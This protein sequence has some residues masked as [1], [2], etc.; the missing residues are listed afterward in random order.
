[1]QVVLAAVPFVLIA[2]V[3]ALVLRRQL[4]GRTVRPRPA[5]KPR[6]TTLTLHVSPDRMDDDLRDLLRKS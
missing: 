1:M 6:A 2:L 4:S 5:R 3:V